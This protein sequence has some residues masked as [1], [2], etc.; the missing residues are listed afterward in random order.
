MKHICIIVGLI[1]PFTGFSQTEQKI[2]S[3][4]VDYC[5]YPHGLDSNTQKIILENSWENIY[6]CNNIC[7][8]KKPQK[9]NSYTILKFE[10][11][12][13]SYLSEGR[14]DLSFYGTCFFDRNFLY[15]DVDEMGAYKI[16]NFI[17][18][19]YLIVEKYLPMGRNGVYKS[20]HRRLLFQMSS[21]PVRAKIKE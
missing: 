1:F 19:E 9:N 7:L 8:N 6:Y 12:F 3:M 17:N 5:H 14:E 20:T 13:F 18:N 21:V 16:I 4:L 10:G 2:K 15:T 11:T